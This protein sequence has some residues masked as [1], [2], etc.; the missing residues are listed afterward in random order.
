[1]T[2]YSQDAIGNWVQQS[3][4]VNVTYRKSR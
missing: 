4:N 3:V 2:A 1:V